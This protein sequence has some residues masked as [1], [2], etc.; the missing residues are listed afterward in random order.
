MEHI[1]IYDIFHQDT[2][3]ARYLTMRY[4]AEYENCMYVDANYW[5]NP[6]EID[7]QYA[8]ILGAYDY[9]EAQFGHD[10]AERLLCDYQNTRIRNGKK[11]NGLFHRHRKPD[12]L[13]FQNGKPYESSDEIFDAM[14]VELEKS[15]HAHRIY[16]I[17]SAAKN[18]V[19][20]R[21]VL[22]FQKNA[23][24]SH[25]MDYLKCFTSC[26]DG[27]LQDKMLTAIFLSNPEYHK[28][29]QSRFESIAD[30]DLSIETVFRE[31]ML[32]ERRNDL[33]IKFGDMMTSENQYDDDIEK[34]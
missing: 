32:L 19:Q 6:R 7:A 25:E 21:S 3:E 2:D 13:D 9:C 16:D 18:P 31:A 26:Q 8:G 30:M 1:M 14:D 27:Y 12:Y 33:D 4:F 20:N 17:K 34:E 5:M 28:Y 23:K 10:E 15:F 24:I 11:V 29:Y 22:F